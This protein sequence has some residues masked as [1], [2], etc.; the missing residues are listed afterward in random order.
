MSHC[1][2]LKT[3]HKRNNIN[4]KIE[5]TSKRSREVAKVADSA[6]SNLKDYHY[7]N[8]T[9]LSLKLDDQRGAR[10]NKIQ[11]INKCTNRQLKY[12]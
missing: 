7:K 11:K 5:Q 10:N 8:K 6:N 2:D 9:R 1:N 3:C 4:M 12:E